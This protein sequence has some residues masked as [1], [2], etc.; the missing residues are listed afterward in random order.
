VLIAGIQEFWGKGPKTSTGEL[1]KFSDNTDL[2]FETLKI[3]RGVLQ[4]EQKKEE[5]LKTLAE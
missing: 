2:C 4:A 3:N 1:Y 5:E